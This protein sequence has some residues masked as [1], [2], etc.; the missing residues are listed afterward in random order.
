MVK[1][2]L[3]FCTLSSSSGLRKYI[4]AHAYTHTDRQTKAETDGK[5]KEGQLTEVIKKKENIIWYFGMYAIIKLVQTC[6]KN[7]RKTLA[8]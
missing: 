7:K 5:N 8:L 2:K 1:E 4:I 6:Y 3:G